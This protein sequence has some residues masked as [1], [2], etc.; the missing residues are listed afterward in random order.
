MDYLVTAARSGLGPVGYRGPWG[1]GA[2]DHCRGDTAGQ[3]WGE[4][5]DKECLHYR[6]SHK[7]VSYASL[8]SQ[9]AILKR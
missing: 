2:S 7:R 6:G 9:E 5:G 8:T 1:G 3:S 4:K